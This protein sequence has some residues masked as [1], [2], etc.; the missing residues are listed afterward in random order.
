MMP[1]RNS[2]KGYVQYH[3][4]AVDDSRRLR[5][6]PDFTAD[7]LTVASNLE[8]CYTRMFRLPIMVASRGGLAAG[9]SFGWRIDGSFVEV[10]ATDQRS[11]ASAVIRVNPNSIIEHVTVASVP[12]STNKLTAHLVSSSCMLLSAI[13]MTALPAITSNVFVIDQSCSLARLLST[14]VLRCFVSCNRRVGFPSLHSQIYLKN[15]ASSVFSTPLPLLPNFL[16]FLQVLVINDA[17][18]R[19][20]ISLVNPATSRITAEIVVPV[21][22]SQVAVVTHNNQATHVAV[23]LDN[24]SL[25]LVAVENLLASDA[26]DLANQVKIVKTG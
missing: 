20:R 24:D 6:L 11:R 26:S 25:C 12:S 19:F 15:D 14:Q 3:F 10:L 17:N 7:H 8:L 13:V 1:T 22:V 4:L 21:S 9:A 23:I 2:T 18:R 16:N 5:F